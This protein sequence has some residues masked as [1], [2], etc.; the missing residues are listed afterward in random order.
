MKTTTTEATAYHNWRELQHQTAKEILNNIPPLPLGYHKHII[1]LHEPN[2]TIKI[3]N[4][5]N[6]NRTIEFEIHINKD[7]KIITKHTTTLKPN[8]HNQYDPHYPLT[9]T[10]NTQELQNPNCFKNIAQ[11]IL[12]QTQ[13]I[14]PCS[15][16][17]SKTA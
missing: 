15:P 2:P 13:Q 16:K 6:N 1:T 14:I 7:L 8:T 10:Q 5:H 12:T 4:H 3:V 9:T 11:Q 17:N